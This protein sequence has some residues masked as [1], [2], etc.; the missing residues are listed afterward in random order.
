MLQ[1][2]DGREKD[3]GGRPRQRDPKPGERVHLGL[4]VTLE[5][6]RRIEAEAVRTGR[7]QS[8]EV[9]ARLERS[10]RDDEILTELAALRE[11]LERDGR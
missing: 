5:M 2:R 1:E 9:E 3:F 10:F 8:Q 4:R 6:K 7:S 11:L